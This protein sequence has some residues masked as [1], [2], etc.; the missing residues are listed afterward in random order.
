PRTVDHDAAVR[1]ARERL[2]PVLAS[3]L[4][5]PAPTEEEIARGLG[6][7]SWRDR[8]Y[9]PR[10]QERIAGWLAESGRELTRTNAGRGNVEIGLADLETVEA[11]VDAG[12][13]DPAKD[14]LAE[15]IAIFL[16]EVLFASLPQSRWDVRSNG[17]PV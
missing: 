13:A 5:E 11:C 17:E 14:R 15:E 8:R 6:R 9:G 16:G 2:G 7:L 1:Y 4:R 3:R 12:R 10:S